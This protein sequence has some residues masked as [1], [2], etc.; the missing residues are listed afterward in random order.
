LGGSYN[1]V[2][3]D[4]DGLNDIKERNL[5]SGN[6]DY[7]IHINGDHH[8]IAGNYIGT[9]AAG[10]TALSNGYY[11]IRLDE[12][13]S[14]TIGGT[15]LNS[16][17]VISGNGDAGIQLYGSNKTVIKGN[18]IGTDQAGESP[19]PNGNN[20]ITLSGSWD[21]VIGSSQRGAQNV[22]ACNT[23]S[24]ILLGGAASFAATNNII[25]GNYIGV[26]RDGETPC[27]NQGMGVGLDHYSVDDTTI[28]GTGAGEGNIIA[29][30]GKDGVRVHYNGTI[31]N[32]IRGNAIYSNSEEGIDL[33]WDS[34]D[35]VT[36]ND[37]DDSDIGPNNYQNYPVLEN[38]SFSGDSLTVSVALTSTASTKFQIDFFLNT[39][40][41]PSGHGEGEI[42]LGQIGRVTDATGEVHFGTTIASLP[43]ESGYLTSTATD[44]DGNTSEFSTC[45]AVAHKVYIPLVMR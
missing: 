23:G 13:T 3:T 30:S 18:L 15:V 2:G 36:P 5:V 38:A 26:F 43:F 16:Y 11:G 33:T 22:I 8:T 41:D 9:N 6:D 27:G 31:N 17:N 12:T 19:L 44:P 29:N 35:G 39:S 40:C 34:N 21:N 20:G 32:S 28:G 14:V 25:Q 4:G 7:G 42:Y 10:N 37:G 1:S 45:L 24:G